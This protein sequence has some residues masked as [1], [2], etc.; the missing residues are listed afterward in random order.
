MGQGDCG[1]EGKRVQQ[2]QQEGSRTNKNIF[3]RWNAMQVFEPPVI[4]DAPPSFVYIDDNEWG[5]AEVSVKRQLQSSFFK[6]QFLFARACVRGIVIM[7]PPPLAGPDKECG[8][9]LTGRIWPR[10]GYRSVDNLKITPTSKF[11]CLALAVSNVA[12]ICREQPCSTSFT[13]T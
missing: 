3:A 9:R 8:S 13:V 11:R 5:L 4:S 6:I 7:I 2:Q 10:L 1:E 12:P